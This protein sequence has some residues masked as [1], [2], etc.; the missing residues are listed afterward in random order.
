MKRFCHHLKSV[1]SFKPLAAECS[2]KAFCRR[3]S[4]HVPGFT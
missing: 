3:V 1:I 2:F 4:L